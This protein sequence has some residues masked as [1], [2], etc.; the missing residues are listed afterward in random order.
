MAYGGQVS[1]NPI[2]PNP[3]LRALKGWETIVEIT[4]D[5]EGTIRTHQANSFVTYRY[6]HPTLSTEYF[7]VESRIRSGR[8]SYIP[9][10]GLLIWH[11]DENGSNNYEQRTESLHYK[12]SVEQADGAFHL[13][14]KANLGGSNDL[15]HAGW[16]DAFD[17]DSVPDALWWSGEPSALQLTRISAV[18]TTISFTVGEEIL[19]QV[20]G[21][22][23]GDGDVDEADLTLFS[24]QWLQNCTVPE[25]CSLCD[26]NQSGE[27]D[28]LDF[29]YIVA[30]WLSGT[31]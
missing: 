4:N 17:D 27:V 7:L 10:E 8:N 22:V 15:F 13:E 24:C 19:P 25:W 9:D 20:P 2:P 29:N 30:N 28:F 14:T 26:F 3:Y 11:I 5:P 16:K 6:S 1:A 23:D 12:V 31:P 21:D 18:G